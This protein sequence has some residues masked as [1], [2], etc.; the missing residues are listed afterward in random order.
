VHALLGSTLYCTRI[1][2]E[3]ARLVVDFA[4]DVGGA[5]SRVTEQ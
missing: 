3:A 2:V 1:F 4:F 5:Q